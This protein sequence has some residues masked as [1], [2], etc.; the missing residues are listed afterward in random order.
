MIKGI[1]LDVDGV[2]VGGKPGVN[3][4]VPHKD[5]ID[6]LRSISRSGIYVS[7]CT[8]K[9][10]FAI[11]RLVKQ[12]GLDTIHISNGGAEVINHVQNKI[13]ENHS[14]DI[15]SGARF[16]K[17]TRA[18]RLY[19]EAYTT[20]GYAIE[21]GSFCKLTEIN[22]SILDTKPLQVSSLEDFVRQN[23]IVKIMPAAFN[24][25]DK[26]TIE[27][28]MSNFSKLQL[29]W[30][31]NLAYAPTLFGVVTQNGVT[32]KSGACDISKHTGIPFDK[33][34]GIGDGLS[35]LEFMQLCTYIGTVANAEEKVKEYVKNRKSNGYIGRSVDENGILDILKYFKVG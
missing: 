32:K 35:D 5:V 4:P 22:M 20:V 6:A 12:I 19:T 25:F 14:I 7:L 9:P 27:S 16:V 28:L 34:L 26:Q 33:M 17:E 10:G 18:R 2:I 15:E 23:E 29:Q 30:G 13:L 31:G 8:A 21:K 24:D 11:S 1:I 3:F